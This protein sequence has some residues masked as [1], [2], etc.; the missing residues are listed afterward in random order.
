MEAEFFIHGPRH[1]FYGKHEDNQYCQLFDNSQIKDNIRFIVEVRKSV[2]GKWYTYY[3]YCRYAN[4]L[5]IDGR[6]GAYIGLTVRIDAY[7]ANLR[8]IY[9]VLEAV[10]MSNVVGLLVKRIPSGFQYIVADFKN[11]YQSILTNVEK[12]LGA[13]LV[14]IIAENDVFTIDS[15][16]HSNGKEIVKGLDDNQYILDRLSDIKKSGKLVFASSKAIDQIEEMNREFERSRDTL[17]EEQREELVQIKRALDKASEREASL[18]NDLCKKNE[19]IALLREEQKAIQNNL[20]IQKKEN[21]KLNEKLQGSSAI[22]DKLNTSLKENDTL[23]KENNYL[24]K[25]IQERDETIKQLK[26]SFNDSSSIES[27]NSLNTAQKHCR[28]INRISLRWN[29]GEFREGLKIVILA[30]FLVVIIA[31]VLLF[32]YNRNNSKMDKKR[33]PMA[34]ASLVSRKQESLAGK[35]INMPNTLTKRLFSTGRDT[36]ERLVVKRSKLDS[37]MINLILDTLHTPINEFEWIIHDSSSAF[38]YQN[39]TSLNSVAFS[40]EKGR[41]CTALVFVNDTLIAKKIIP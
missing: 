25:E 24:E 36:T 4:I 17:K 15:S 27:K 19:Q 5:D 41:R 6:R 14:G 34:E 1:A 37:N 3:N 20:F 10:F 21:D 30:F 16:F 8:N 9:T 7:Y 12:K 18:K 31:L 39:I 13:L 2:N 28:I 33:I 40:L 26:S 11:S 32:F 35:F 23:R 29:L 38:R 22:M